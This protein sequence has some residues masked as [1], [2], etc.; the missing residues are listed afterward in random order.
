MT[1]IKVEWQK[2]ESEFDQNLSTFDQVYT[3]VRFSIMKRTAH[4]FENSV[5]SVTLLFSYL[6]M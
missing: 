2:N 5:F 1:D 3:V 4:A 6:L